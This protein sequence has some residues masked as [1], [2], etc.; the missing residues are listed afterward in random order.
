MEIIKNGK[1]VELAYKIFLVDKDGDTMIYEFKEDKPDYFVFGHEPGMLESFTSHLEGLKAGDNFDFILSPIEAFGERNPDLVQ[2]LDKQLFVIE[3]EFDSDRVY[4][5]AFVPM[6]TGDGMRIEGIVK[7]ITDDTVTIDFNHQ[8]AGETVKYTGKVINVRE[9]TDEE[10]NPPHHCGG[11][12]GGE[13]GG[14]CD[15]EGDGE[16]CGNGKGHHHGDG[17]CCGN[18]HGHHHGDG[19]CC[20]NGKGHHHGDG[21][22]CGNGKGHH[23]GDGECCGNGKDKA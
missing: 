23:H 10:K 7:N 2:V 12:G 13:C 6:M 9:A 19:E 3:G 17:E 5:G 1:M 4:E 14:N 18:G 11:C 15:K 22:C 21:E 8:L 20:G 16:C